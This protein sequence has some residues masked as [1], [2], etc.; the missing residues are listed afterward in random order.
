VSAPIAILTGVQEP[1]NFTVSRDGV[2]LAGL[3]YPGDGIPVV[4]FHG[5]AGYAGEW[6]VTAHGLEGR[7]IVA[8][9]AR[10]HGRSERHPEDVSIA[11]HAADAAHVIE[12]LELGQVVAI[13]QSLGGLTAI[14]LAATHPELVKALVVVDA[15]P[16]A[17]SDHTVSEVE[18]SLRRWP[19]PFDSV[20]AA[21]QYFGGSPGSAAAW[22]NGLEHREDGWWPRFDFDVMTR[23]LKEALGNDYW[24]EWERVRCPVLVLRA[25]DGDVSEA[26]A[27]EMTK[28]LATARTIEIPGAGHDL[29]LDRPDEWQA[30][31]GGFLE[32]I[33]A[34]A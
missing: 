32:A 4:L 5:L 14:T 17:G 20:L 33:D 22:A 6:R 13:G 34:S 7:R 19:V 26:S 25:E 21:A 8:V 10:G 9:D 27:E 2:R 15:D 16:A 30:V 31:L 29:H 28:R 18:A 11:A 23:T 12:E 1:S 3:D 24:A